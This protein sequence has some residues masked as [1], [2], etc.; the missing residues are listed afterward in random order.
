MPTGCCISTY[1]N[2]NGWDSH[3]R[4][5]EEYSECGGG[6]LEGHDERVVIEKEKKERE[7]ERERVMQVSGPCLCLCRCL[8][9]GKCE[10]SVCDEVC[11]VVLVA[12]SFPLRSRLDDKAV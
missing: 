12:L 2:S 7:R 1:L 8:V 4:S 5:T 10:T 3:D 9:V 11:A 6:G